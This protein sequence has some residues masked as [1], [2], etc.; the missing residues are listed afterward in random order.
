MNKNYEKCVILHP[1]FPL[2]EVSTIKKFFSRLDKQRKCVIGFTSNNED[3][4]QKI[5]RKNARLLPLNNKNEDIVKQE[6]IVG[7]DCEFILKNK[8]F[9]KN[10][11]GVKIPKS[12]FL[13]LNNYHSFGTFEKIVTRK[14][15]LIRVHGSIEIGLG[16]V[17]N[18]LTILN[19]LRNEE[20]LI[21]MDKK[22]SLGSKKFREQLYNLKYFSNEQE[23]FRIINEFKPDI[24]FNDILDT[25]INYMKKLKQTNSFLVNFEDLG[26]GRKYADL[27]F[28]PIFNT[29]SKSFKSS[30]K[31]YR[32]FK[33]EYFG[34]DYACV[35]DEFRMWKRETQRRDVKDIL[36]SFGGADPFN[37]TMRILKI[38]NKLKFFNVNLI[39][40]LGI[41][42][43]GKEKI[44]PLIN[45]MMN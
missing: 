11:Y 36:I 5:E 34:S 2:I 25:S 3:K 37:H 45:E 6:K 40:I 38:F 24:I 13:E 27:T 44:Q 4:F 21:V 1:K 14:K 20:L 15:I 19:H 29:A 30:M 32:K 8:V 43:A 12:E 33:N 39:V 16:H 41:G 10:K 42:Y 31:N 17:Y 9:P 22:S 26:E 28:N 7:F 18:M 23:L 35:R